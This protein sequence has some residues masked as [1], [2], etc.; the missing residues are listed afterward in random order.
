MN[1]KNLCGA[2]LSCLLLQAC[3][4]PMGMLQRDL[5]IQEPQIKELATPEPIINRQLGSVNFNTNKICLS[6]GDFAANLTYEFADQRFKQDFPLLLEKQLRESGVFSSAA[7]Q[8][9]NVRATLLY[10]KQKSNVGE[11]EERKNPMTS[12]AVL[13]A[14]MIVGYELLDENKTIGFWKISSYASSNS[15]SSVSRRVDALDNLLTRNIRAFILRMEAD[16]SPKEASRAYRAFA[17]IY[18]ESN[19]T[20]TAAGA[21]FS[22]TAKAVSATA[23][24]IGDGLSLVAQNSGAIAAGLNSTAET[25]NSM[26]QEMNKNYTN[27]VMGN[28]SP[29][30]IHLTSQENDQQSP[31]ISKSD[32]PS[33]KITYSASNTVHVRDCVYYI[34][35]KVM[36]SIDRLS[37]TGTH[38]GEEGAIKSNEYNRSHGIPEC[39]DPGPTV[40]TNGTSR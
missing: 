26:N 20:R 3:T 24:A 12:S 18:G 34:N 23:G 19:D 8:R 25:M 1:Y 13:M 38:S 32:I 40:P 33:E 10:L 39:P 35:V 21:I 11:F 4:T 16:L 7:G 22:G 2:I 29:Y 5:A 9:L 37:G 31:S 14:N 28:R 30:L 6:C 15:L 27:A 17:A 36:A